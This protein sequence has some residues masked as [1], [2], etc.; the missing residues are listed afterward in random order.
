MAQ[1]DRF[2]EMPLPSF[3]DEYA[4]KNLCP[5]GG[6]F[7]LHGS[8]YGCIDVWEMKEY[9]VTESWV[10]L[11][12]TNQAD[13]SQFFRQLVPPQFVKNGEIL[14]GYDDR[15]GYHLDLYDIK[16]GTSINLKAY[17]NWGWYF[18]ATFVYVERLLPLNSG[19]Y[20]G[21]R[22]IERKRLQRR[23][24]ARLQDQNILLNIL[25]RLP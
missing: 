6:S 22:E 24:M 2:D 5:L 23:R 20:V 3:C 25:I 7:C 16:L 18:N 21:Q 14:L 15:K 11:F 1:D 12:T 8:I 17:A 19:T 4:E 13:P 9:G 10:K